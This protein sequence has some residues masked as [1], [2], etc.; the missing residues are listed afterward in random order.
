M[1]ALLAAYMWMFSMHSSNAIV[2]INFRIRHLH[3][4]HIYWTAFPMLPPLANQ[5]SV[6]DPDSRAIYHQHTSFSARETKSTSSIWTSIMSTSSIPALPS[7]PS[8]DEGPKVIA[9]TVCF[10]ILSTVL[11]A[12]RMYVRRFIRGALGWDDLLMVI[13]MVAVCALPVAT[14]ERPYTDQYNRISLVLALSSWLSKMEVGDILVTLGWKCM[15]MD[16]TTHSLQLPC[17]SCHKYSPRHRLELL[18]FELL[19]RGRIELPR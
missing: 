8:E 14:P 12:L 11:I 13:A 18:S 4:I 1:L 3:G 7:N 2:P 5:R 16:C 19:F 9:I 10:N 17:W 6:R 15:D